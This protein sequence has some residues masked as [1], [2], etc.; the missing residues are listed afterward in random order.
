MTARLQAPEAIGQE[1]VTMQPRVSAYT[2]Q[3]R[4]DNGSPL[5]LR[6]THAVQ[7]ALFG[8]ICGTPERKRW[9]A[10]REQRQH[11]LGETD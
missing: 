9:D 7:G 10:V 11:E 4:Q 1:G 5:N 3:I 8:P 2:L 6:M